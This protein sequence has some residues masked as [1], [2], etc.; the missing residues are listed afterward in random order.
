MS[1]KLST[2]A[3]RMI[4]GKCIGQAPGM[5]RLICLLFP[6]SDVGARQGF[7]RDMQGTPYDTPKIKMSIQP[8]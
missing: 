4:I 7:I 1:Q 5:L 8:K 3:V 2:A 6:I